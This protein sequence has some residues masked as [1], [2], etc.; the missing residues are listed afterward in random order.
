GSSGLGVAKALRN[1]GLIDQYGHAT[2]AEE[3]CRDIQTGPVLMGLP[4]LSAFFEPDRHGFVD[5]DPKWANSGTAGGHEVCITALEDV[6]LD[7]HGRLI[8]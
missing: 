4:W 1:R 8:P 7:E 3:L 5:H 6:A 2:S